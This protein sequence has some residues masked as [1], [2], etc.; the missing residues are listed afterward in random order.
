MDVRL[1]RGLKEDSP[2]LALASRADAAAL[3]LV[4]S[5]SLCTDLLLLPLLLELAVTRNE[6]GHAFA[7]S[8]HRNIAP[9]NCSA[10]FM[11]SCTVY[12]QHCRSCTK[13]ITKTTA[14]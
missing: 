7:D 11:L 8:A 5:S 12:R 4:C 3:G 13:S 10:W 14:L 1:A 6:E 2:T 9:V